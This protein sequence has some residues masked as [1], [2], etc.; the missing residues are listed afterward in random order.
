MTNLA[1]RTMKPQYNIMR[2]KLFLFLLSLTASL[3]ILIS[4]SQI[5]GAGN[6]YGLDAT[7]KKIDNSDKIFNTTKTLPERVGQI[8]GYI[9]SFVG[10]IFFL[11]I[12][13]GGFKWMTARG[14]EKEVNDAKELIYSSIIGIV[15]IFSA[16]ILTSYIGGLLT[17]K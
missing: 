1:V 16:Y 12:I 2:N 15:I 17:S 4:P 8:V 10:T 5:I 3:S 11:L 7:M 13:Y 6:D 9:L 14:N